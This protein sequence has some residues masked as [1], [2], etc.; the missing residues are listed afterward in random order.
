MI[1]TMLLVPAVTGLLVV[2]APAAHAALVA[3]GCRLVPAGAAGPAAVGYALFDDQGTH[4]LRCYVTVDGTERAGTPT[5][6][7]TGLVVLSS[8]IAYD[9]ESWRSALC[10]EVDGVTVLC[11]D[12]PD[13][14]QN[15]VDAIGALC[16]VDL[17]LYPPW[18]DATLCPILSSLSPGVP[19]VVDIDPEG[20]T[21]VAGVGQ[22]WDCPPYGG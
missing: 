10:T 16:D 21:S 13:A 17:C 12:R 14:V 7:G 15:T 8:P 22:V 18:L 3:G 9:A 5:A 6:S 4:T 11:A 20:D 1:R 19:G 2:N